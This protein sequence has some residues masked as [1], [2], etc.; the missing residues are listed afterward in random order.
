M[1]KQDAIATVNRCCGNESLSNSNTAFS[2]ESTAKP[3]WWL[4]IA[5]QKFQQELN[6]LLAHGDDRIIWLRIPPDTFRPPFPEF[7]IRN[8]G[9]VD[10]EISCDENDRYLHDTKSKG[11]GYDFR[12][13]V[14]RDCCVSD[15]NG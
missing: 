4:N 3:V 1:D 15:E 9:K 11:T 12:P 7:R 8:T 5:P 13:F 6:I 14:V 10:L 2:N